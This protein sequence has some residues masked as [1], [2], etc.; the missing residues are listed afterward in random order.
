MGNVNL[1][2]RVGKFVRAMVQAV[3]FG[4]THSGQ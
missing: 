4:D 1:V 3:D 2:S